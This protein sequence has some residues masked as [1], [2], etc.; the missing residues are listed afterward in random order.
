M[1]SEKPKH[2]FYHFYLCENGGIIRVMARRRPS[3]HT[4]PRGD[5]WALE[6]Y[7]PDQERWCFT[8]EVTWGRLRELQYIGKVEV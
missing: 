8:W 2:S 7:C 6:E 5:T 1:A 4:R 3:K